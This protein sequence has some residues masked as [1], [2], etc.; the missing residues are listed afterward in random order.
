MIYVALFFLD[1]I[2][3]THCLPKVVF[4]SQNY[5][6][7]TVEYSNTLVKITKSSFDTVIFR[8]IDFGQNSVVIIANGATVFEGH[9]RGHEDYISGALTSLV[10]DIDVFI[11]DYVVDIPELYQF[12]MAIDKPILFIHHDHHS[13][14]Y[15]MSYEMHLACNRYVPTRIDESSPQE[16]RHRWRYAQIMSRGSMIITDSLKNVELFSQYRPY[17]TMLP[18]PLEVFNNGVCQVKVN[19]PNLNNKDE[20]I[21]VF[22]G[23]FSHTKGSRIALEVSKH[24]AQHQPN[25][26]VRIFHIGNRFNNDEG[27][28]QHK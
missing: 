6:G 14:S 24:F 9:L 21:I 23:Q 18:A 19:P 13:V 5:G 27:K 25:Q 8:F 4:V 1:I 20:M 22:L 17:L 2:R 11:T 12:W 16:A 26:P 7:G 28:Q 10:G 3:S 15:E